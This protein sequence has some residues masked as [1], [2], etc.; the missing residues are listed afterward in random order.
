VP[1]P[2][3]VTVSA[4][5][6]WSRNGD[7]ADFDIPIE[8]YS[9]EWQGTIDWSAEGDSTETYSNGSLV[10]TYRADGKAT[11]APAPPGSGLSVDENGGFLR[12]NSVS[13]ASYYR[14]VLTVTIN[15][16][17]CQVTTTDITVKS[18]GPT[19]FTTLPPDN[20]PFKA[21]WDVLFRLRDDGQY[22]I[23]GGIGPV[24]V[25]V[26]DTS[27]RTTICPGREPETITTTD[28]RDSFD[29]VLGP[30]DEIRRFSPGDKVFKNQV[31]NLTE[32]DIQISTDVNWTFTRP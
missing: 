6:T 26:A 27:I 19:R 12:A 24:P 17:P 25:T 1:D 30:V 32:R 31:I 15:N 21:L 5:M 2:A 20:D 7:K 13:A 28:Q 9:D 22:V 8:I 18:S 4:E 29:A 23:S 11:Y 3:T 14:R 10:I 16:D